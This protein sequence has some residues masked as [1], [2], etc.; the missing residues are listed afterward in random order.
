MKSRLWQ[1][2]GYKEQKKKADGTTQ[3]EWMTI[4]KVYD[5]K[6]E[7]QALEAAQKIIKRPFWHLQEVKEWEQEIDMSN[8]QLIELQ[9]K[10]FELQ[11]KALK[12]FDKLK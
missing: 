6:T 4:V 3:L 1:F 2:I 5:Y 9:I 8:K 7:S 10:A 11:I 12:K